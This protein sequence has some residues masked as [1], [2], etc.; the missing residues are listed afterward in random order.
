MLEL[1][2]T[3]GTTLVLVTHDP[4]VARLTERTIRLRNGEMIE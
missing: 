2:R 4:D 1:N 3:A